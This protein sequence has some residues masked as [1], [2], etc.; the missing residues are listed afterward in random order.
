M[1]GH[2]P[3]PAPMRKE[4]NADDRTSPPVPCQPARRPQALRAR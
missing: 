3:A 2:Q 1:T 4:G